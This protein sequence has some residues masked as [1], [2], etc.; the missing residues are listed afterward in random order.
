MCEI[1]KEAYE[2][3]R[4]KPGFSRVF[5][6][7][8]KKWKSY[9]R[10]AGMVK[11]T[12]A[13]E[14]ER[15]ALEGFFGRSFA[16]KTLSFSLQEFEKTLQ[17][18]SFKS[19]DL[20]QL[21]ELYFGEPMMTNAQCRA[22]KEMQLQSFFDGCRHAFL[23]KA[24]DLPLYRLSADWIAA[25]YEEKSY[26]YQIV[27]REWNRN[28]ENAEKLVMAAGTALCEVLPEDPAV[29]EPGP[30]GE[31]Q[32][33]AV[34]ASR[35]SGNPH[36]FDRGT[37]PGQLL[38]CSLCWHSGA[39]VP[40]G[41][42]ELASLYLRYGILMDEISSTVAVFGI[43][44]ER[45]GR[46]HPGAEGFLQ[47]REPFLLMQ[48]NM[49]G[50][51]R[52]FGDGDVIFVVENEMVFSHL[53]RQ[54]RDLSGERSAAVLCTMGQPRKAAWQLLDLL[55]AENPEIFYSG[56]LDPE[57]MDIAERIWKRHPEQVI[58]WRMG[59]EDYKR[60]VSEEE[61]DERRLSILRRLKNPQLQE[62]AELLR[63]EKKAGYQEALLDEMFSDIR[64]KFQR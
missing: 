27:L 3:F 62:T 17:E 59:P 39:A 42:E 34:L 9:G 22:E 7:M 52:A 56:D 49:D 48:K 25:V 61:I 8:R 16:G 43:H 53:C 15:R 10:A 18:T 20:R 11:L 14:E 47:E 23:K 32:M 60:S 24:A 35:V 58:L 30:G 29:C 19:L 13:T 26:G 41:A 31:G 54:C 37:A 44:L 46:L 45:N 57:G 28:P 55:A 21:L 51:T 4:K 64:A 12:D 2:Y 5:L 63:E 38:T 33:L 36:F 40:S 50:I 6:Q 1:R